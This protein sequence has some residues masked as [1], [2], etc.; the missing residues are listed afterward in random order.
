MINAIVTGHGEFSLGMV[1]ALEMIAGEQEGMKAIPFY[2]EDSMEN[3]QD[4]MNEALEDI[5]TGTSHT[6][7]FT[8]LK[9]GTPF[10][11]SMLLTTQEDNVSV[12]GG[13][14]LPILLEF[15]GKRWTEGDTEEILQSLVEVASE[16]VMVGKL[17]IQENDIDEDGI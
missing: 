9:G 5:S 3:Y 16:G 6:I 1:N 14:N 17:T 7:I 11:V 13:T 2:N 4:K 10:N 15:I 8:D 12:V